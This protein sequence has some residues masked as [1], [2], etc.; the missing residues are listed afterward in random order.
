MN[1]D[2]EFFKNNGYCII[3]DVFNSVEMAEF[4]TIAYETLEQDK[5]NKKGKKVVTDI[6]NVFYP[7]GDL[8]TRPLKKVLLSDKILKIADTILDTKPVYFG[9]STYQIGIGDRGFHRD[10]VDRIANQGEDWNG[11]YDIIRI[12]VYMQDHDKYSGGLKVIAG[13]HIGK[14]GK[15]VF[16]DSKAGDVVVWNLRTLHSGNAAR[17]KVWPSL[18]M[19]YRLENMLPKFLMKDSQQERISCFMSFAKEGKDLD[20]YVEKYMKVK[21]V[22]HIKSSNYSGLIEGLKNKNVII[23]EIDCE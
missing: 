10:N 5:L 13:S 8:L 15:R 12:G 1:I 4:R 23:K 7:S 2:K 20:R 6:K 3:K 11:D 9:D 22:E 18:A 16:V 21:M 17:L 14:N 19:G